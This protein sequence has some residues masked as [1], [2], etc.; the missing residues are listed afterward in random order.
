MRAHGN[1]SIR[2]MAAKNPKGALEKF[3]YVPEPLGPYDVEVSI[4]ACGVCHSDVHLIDNDWGISTYPLVPGHEIVGYVH[5]KGGMVRDL[6]IGQR[7]GIGW[8][9]A[10]CLHC[11]HCN[12]GDENLCA[13]SQATCVG[14]FGGFASEI[15]LDSRFAFP[16]PE[17]LASEN[18]AP[19]LCGGITV[20][21]PLL[22]DVKPSM[23]VGVIGVGGLGHLAIQFA[24]AFGCEVTAFSHSPDK[25]KEARQFG[26][27]RF[28]SSNDTS[29]MK[30]VAGSLDYILAT[31][32]AD[33]DWM[34]Y[35]NILKPR[36]KLCF[37]GAVP[38]PIQIPALALIGGRKSVSGSN[39]GSRTEIMQMLEFAARHGIVAKTE[40]LPMAD[41]N[42][43]IEKV[44][45]NEARYRMVLKNPEAHSH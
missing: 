26:A 28:I 2:A 13:S 3:E 41:A 35:L 16:I 22:R 34:A 12:Q 37:V 29:A 30:S 18:A 42:K 38:A 9:R 19:L 45:K 8:Q 31:A 39:I 11:E 23:K 5:E 27:S 10:S 17:K 1:S 43:A 33:L 14:H 40:T 7:V 20:F 6:K 32:S 21:A 36:G 15:R 44:R 24:K 4:E 25:E